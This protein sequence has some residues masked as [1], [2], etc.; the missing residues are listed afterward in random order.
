MSNMHT[1][2]YSSRFEDLFLVVFIILYESTIV[3]FLLYNINTLLDHFIVHQLHEERKIQMVR[4]N[5]G[6][7]HILIS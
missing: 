1:T 5:L 6:K 2:L 4:C 3:I 7:L